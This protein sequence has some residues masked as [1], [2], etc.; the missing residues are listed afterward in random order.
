M[1]AQIMDFAL[2]ETEAAFKALRCLYGWGTKTLSMIRISDVP[3]LVGIESQRLND[4]WA[5]CRYE[6]ETEST[7]ILTTD[8][9]K[10][11]SLEEDK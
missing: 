6:E 8:G 9:W 4:L 2:D 7:Y 5:I 10:M 3:P 11:W 1:K